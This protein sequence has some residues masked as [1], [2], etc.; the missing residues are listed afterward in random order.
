MA[1]STAVGGIFKVG[2]PSEYVQGHAMIGVVT[3]LE[4]AIPVIIYYTWAYR[5]IVDLDLKETW[6]GYAW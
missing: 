6:Y 2:E 5:R 4:A 1:N 3:F